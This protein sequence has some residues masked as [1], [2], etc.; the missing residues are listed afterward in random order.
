[1]LECALAEIEMRPI[2]P[3]L[4]L[5]IVIPAFNRSPELMLAITGIA[6]QLTGG[7]EHKVEIIISDNGSSE[8][9]A[10]AIRHVA[11]QYQ[12]VSFLRHARD[13]GGFFNYFAAPWRAR[14]RYMWIF[15][16]DDV[17][18]PGGVAQ[19]VQML[20]REQPSFATLNKRVYNKDL[21]QEIWPAANTVPDRR[22]DTFEDLMCAL[23]INQLAFISGNIELTETARAVD[24]RPFLKMDTRHPHVVAF[25]QRHHGA[26]AVYVSSA[27]LIHRL[28]NSALPHYHLGNFF[29]YAATLPIHLHEVLTSIGASADFFDRMTGDKRIQTYELSGP[30]FVDNI[31]ENLLR[32]MAGGKYLTVSYRRALEE[33]LSH[34]RADRVQQLNDIWG[35]QDQV[36]I[37]EQ[38][39]EDSKS[40]LAQGR[41]ACSQVSRNF[42]RQ[43]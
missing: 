38:Q 6:D 30:T 25:L 19:V 27:H 12:T 16:S 35:M 7:L 2:D 24:P 1:L 8:E 40:M 11:G 5:S 32:S 10:A 22:F 23:G 17:L 37:L 14:G 21:T 28:E 3:A 18:L 20:E 34:C 13:E 31:F 9:A 29:D 42:V 15:G 33:I 4:L 26:P 43:S 41:E 36:M 39:V